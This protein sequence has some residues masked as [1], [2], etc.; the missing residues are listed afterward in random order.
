MHPAL[1]IGDI[2]YLIFEYCDKNELARIARTCQSLFDIATDRLWN[3]ILSFDP[4]IPFV[5]D[6]QKYPRNSELRK[7]VLA[8]LDMYAAKVQI[9]FMEG[10]LDHPIRIPKDL[11]QKAEPRTQLNDEPWDDLW[12][13]KRATHRPGSPFFLPN[14]R[15]IYANHVQ[16][17]A[18]IP[19]IRVS[20][21]RLNRIEIKYLQWR[22]KD[23][24]I[25]RILH[26]M[27]THSALQYLYIRDG[28]S[29]LIPRSV[30]L[31]APLKQLRLPPKLYFDY[32]GASYGSRSLR[33]DV[34][35]IPTLENLTI[36]LTPD[37]YTT[38]LGGPTVKVL[39]ALKELWLDMS[40][41]SPS[42]CYSLN[43]PDR[44]TANSWTCKPPLW[45]GGSLKYWKC[46]RQPPTR[47]FEKLDNPELNRL[48][49]KLPC[50]TN[51]DMLRVLIASAK[52]NCRLEVLKHLS[53][54]RA[55]W[56]NSF[57]P[58]KI[59]PI[60]LRFNLQQL[61][62]LPQLTSLNLTV[63]PNFLDLFDL[64]GY[65][66][67]TQGLPKLRTLVLGHRD[68][69][70]DHNTFTNQIYER[71]PFRNLAAFCSM[72][73]DLLEVR[74]PSIDVSDLEEDPR[75][76]WACPSVEMLLVRTKI[77]MA[78]VQDRL[79]ACQRTWFP[80]VVWAEP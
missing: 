54:V 71:T 7:N 29:E 42:Y 30:F 9:V 26:S 47:F 55:G 23:R 19:L 59:L 45:D 60:D 10:S 8:R 21:A 4:F 72:L 51:G 75:L 37:W 57:Q 39:P 76:E 67:I 27:Q 43:C 31:S 58:S 73:P 38:D 62:P 70:G 44:A 28:D 80:N 40:T 24:V 6:I 68:Y 69:N 16:E 65:K 5:I 41:F 64:E 1:L 36:P 17:A 79:E 33:A 49:I 11:Q 74:I 77:G 34:L 13:Q 12:A 15:H 14:L 78:S 52:I 20:G 46:K 35:K 25:K 56:E 50:D 61:L 3:T 66:E 63:A 48:Y 32:T 18:L 22:R 53:W 2:Q